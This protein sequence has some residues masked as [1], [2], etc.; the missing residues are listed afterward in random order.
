MALSPISRG[1]FTVFKI[2]N[3]TSTNSKVLKWLYLDSANVFFTYQEGQLF[4]LF[5]IML[6]I[7]LLEQNLC[8]SNKYKGC[9]SDK[10]KSFAHAKG[11]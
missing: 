1:S 10:N 3:S 8:M 7:F 6:H 11:A 2:L 5:P 9:I 4:I